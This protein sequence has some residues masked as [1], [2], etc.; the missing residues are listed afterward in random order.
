[1][2]KPGCFPRELCRL[3]E[4]Q[5]GEGLAQ[6]LTQGGLHRDTQHSVTE[7]LM[8][9]ALL[10]CTSKTLIPTTKNTTTAPVINC[11]C[12]QNCWV[13]IS[14]NKDWHCHYWHYWR[15]NW[16]LERS[17]LG[18]KVKDGTGPNQ[19]YLGLE[20]YTRRCYILCDTG[21]PSK[22]FMPCSHLTYL[23][24]SP[25]H[26]RYFD[27]ENRARLRQTKYPPIRRKNEKNRIFFCQNP[28]CRFAGIFSPSKAQWLP[29]P[30]TLMPP[31]NLKLFKTLKLY[32]LLEDCNV[33]ARYHLKSCLSVRTILFWIPAPA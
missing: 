26:S 10:S 31:E 3:T 13:T 2:S 12:A 22:D 28:H 15:C 17:H 8:I 33:I 29:F 6:C 27:F 1:M 30:S 4:V 16:G 5:H 23:H 19:V 21:V 14:R 32:Y 7:V 11:M 9:I 20:S 24:R 18:Q 25:I